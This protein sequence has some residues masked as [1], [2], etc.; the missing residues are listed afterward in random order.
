MRTYNPV[1]PAIEVEVAVFSSRQGGE[2]L[3]TVAPGAA[4]KAADDRYEDQRHD[5]GGGKCGDQGNGQKL[6]EFAD[7]ARPE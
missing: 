1:A 6:H 7:H 5:Q 2:Y 4:N 3:G